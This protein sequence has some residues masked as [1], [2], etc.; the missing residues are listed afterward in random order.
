MRA[1]IHVLAGNTE[2]AHDE[3][4]RTRDLLESRLR[5]RPEDVP[6]MLQLSCVNVALNRNDQAVRLAHHATELVPVEKDALLGPTYLA[7]VAEIEARTGDA[8]AAVKTLQRLLSMPIGYYISIQQLK[9]D[10]VWDSIRKDQGFQQ[11]LLG[12]E[13]I[14]PNM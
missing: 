6:K 12:Q 8:G 4:A 13:L 2:M 5:E 7:C 10:P 9:I 11:L 1:A 3:T 14:G